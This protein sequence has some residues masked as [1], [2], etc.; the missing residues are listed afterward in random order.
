MLK[1]EMTAHAIM[2]IPRL[3]EC[4]T[5]I[6]LGDIIMEASNYDRQSLRYLTSTGVIYIV[7]FDG[8]LITGYMGNM[9]QVVSIYRENGIDRLP[10]SFY[11]MVKRNVVKYDYLL[12]MK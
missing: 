2:R 7:G 9:S 10:N 1:F 8:K 5:T 4:A 11:K 6:G 12:E 3:V